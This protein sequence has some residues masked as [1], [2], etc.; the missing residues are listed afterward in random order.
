M[1][2]KSLWPGW[3][4]QLYSEKKGQIDLFGQQSFATERDSGWEKIEELVNEKM[5]SIFPHVENPGHLFG[6]K[7]APLFSLYF[8]VSNSS[9]AAH[10][11]ASPIARALLNKL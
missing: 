10:R 4:E 11:V 5:R 8:A 7:G 9:P 6:P 2:D 3:E 1:V